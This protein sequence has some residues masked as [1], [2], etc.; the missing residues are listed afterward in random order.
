MISCPIFESR[1]AVGSSARMS[2]G[3]L[4]SARAIATRCFSPPDSF[5]GRKSSRSPRPEVGQERRR[6]VARRAPAEPGQLGDDRHVLAGGQRRKQVEVLED[7]PELAEPDGGQP[8]L[9]ERADIGAVEVDRARGR[10]EQCAHHRQERRLA[11]TRRAHDQDDLARLDGERD[12]TNGRDRGLALAKA[13]VTW[14][15]SSVRAPIRLL[16]EDDGRVETRDLS[17]GQDRGEAGDDR[18]DEQ[19]TLTTERPLIASSRFSPCAG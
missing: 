13:L 14:L 7:E 8:T 1:L 5:S 10:P 4:I 19:P 17:D 9:G 11:R 16:S 18:G 15:T 6:L 3:S 12:V 2:V